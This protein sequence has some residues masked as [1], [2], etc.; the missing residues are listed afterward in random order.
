[1][2]P[3]VGTPG[4]LPTTPE[5]AAFTISLHTAGPE[6]QGDLSGA[7]NQKYF[8]RKKHLDWPIRR[9]E[10]GVDPFKLPL[11][12]HTKCNQTRRAWE[13]STSSVQPRPDGGRNLCAGRHP[14]AAFRACAVAQTFFV[15]DRTRRFILHAVA[16]FAASLSCAEQAL[17]WRRVRL[18]INIATTEEGLSRS[19]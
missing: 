3:M 18:L 12:L 10:R 1:M 17:T 14:W 4:R 15:R 19:G 11:V 16:A 7:A 13:V 2:S 6:A 9:Q 5:N 8:A